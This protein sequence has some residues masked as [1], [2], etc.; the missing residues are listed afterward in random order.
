MIS[1]ISLAAVQAVRINQA[2][3]QAPLEDFT[4]ENAVD[5]LLMKEE[6]PLEGPTAD[7]NELVVID[8]YPEENLDAQLESKSQTIW[9]SYLQYGDSYDYDEDSDSIMPKSLAERAALGQQLF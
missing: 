5:Y 7:A 9:T 6:S 4:Y 3:W 1:A 2:S 8:E